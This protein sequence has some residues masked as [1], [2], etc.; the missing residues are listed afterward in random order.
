MNCVEESQLESARASRLAWD[1]TLASLMRAHSDVALELRH[2][3]SLWISVEGPPDAKAFLSEE[4]VEFL[5][6]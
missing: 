4:F 6:R 2:D 5:T 3:R 1:F